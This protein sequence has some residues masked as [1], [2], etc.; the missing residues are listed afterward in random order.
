MYTLTLIR[1]KKEPNQS[2]SLGGKY[3]ERLSFSGFATKAEAEKFFNER[4]K[5]EYNRDMARGYHFWSIH[6]TSTTAHTKKSL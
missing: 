1:P 2:L 6:L 5:T 3:E 4:D